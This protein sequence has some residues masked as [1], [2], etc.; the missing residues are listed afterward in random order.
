[1]SPPEELGMVDWSALKDAYGPAGEVPVWIRALYAEQ[2]PE[3]EDG[4]SVIGE[5]VNHINHQGSIHPATVAAVPFLAHLALHRDF[6]RAGLLHVLT[7]LAGD[8][9]EGAE[10]DPLSERLRAAVVAELPALI[11]C[12]TDPDSAVRQQAIRLTVVAPQPL[13]PAVRATL[14][15]LSAHD[16]DAWTRADAMTALAVTDPDQDAVRCREARALADDAPEVRLSAAQLG[17]ERAQRPFPAALVNIVAVDGA[18]DLG[19]YWATG[20]LEPFPSP[21]PPDAR[22]GDVL[23]QDPQAALT[24]AE[25]WIAAGD[26]DYRGSHL[27]DDVGETWRD[28][29]SRI[30]AALARAVPLSR[31]VTHDQWMAPAREAWLLQQLADWMPRAGDPGPQVRDM[32]LAQACRDAPEAAASAQLALG[33]CGDLRL[34]EAGAVPTDEAIAALVTHH[35]PNLPPV[36]H[37]ALEEHLP[38]GAPA[39]LDA[40][41]P[42]TA[43]TYAAHIAEAFR[44]RP[45]FSAAQLLGTLDPDLVDNATLDRLAAAR[46]DHEREAV[47]ATAAVSHALL[48]GWP[49]AAIGLLRELLAGDSPEWILPRAGRLGSLG[50]P[51]AAQVRGLFA[52]RGGL[53]RAEAADAYWRITADPG[54]VLPLLVELAVPDREPHAD[55]RAWHRLEALRT[56]TDIGITPP[57]LLPLL[58]ACARSPHRV[59]RPDE[60]E[61][62]R[63]LAVGLLARAR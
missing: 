50:T 25:A 20:R 63:E 59:A 40:L 16:P 58:D 51:L 8:P 35:E 34:L 17:L 47:R 44:A 6:H 4:E 13:D 26:V 45:T 54:P 1:M 55:D 9:E 42:A 27:A 57:E 43:R 2:D 39:L 3:T 62:L 52:G 49:G 14:S 48:T 22:L 15:D 33:H 19:C 21:G 46:R 23:V 56:L 37:R 11:T 32:L 28:Q 12:L 60:D 31:P 7:R 38:Q 53:G 5:L 18:R 24:V 10:R 36:L 61:E 29:D 41:T 30:A